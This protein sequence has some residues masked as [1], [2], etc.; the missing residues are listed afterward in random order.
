MN[1]S[2]PDKLAIQQPTPKSHSTLLVV[3]VLVVLAVSLFLAAVVFLGSWLL[4]DSR[5][6]AAAPAVAF[7]DA[8]SVTTDW[9]AR[10]ASDDYP[11]RFDAAMGIPDPG[12]RDSALAG[13]AKAAASAAQASAGDPGCFVSS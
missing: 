7:E 11:T 10:G 4:F 8:S 12:E 5:E 3:V 9:A 6:P 2:L 13:L 1:A